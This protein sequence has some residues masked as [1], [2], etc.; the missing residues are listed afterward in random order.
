MCEEE[1]D[2]REKLPLYMWSGG[3]TAQCFLRCHHSSPN[4][5]QGLLCC[6]QADDN[7]VVVIDNNTV[8]GW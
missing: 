8:M 4:F 1:G 5:Q 7:G 2:S 3:F 6:C